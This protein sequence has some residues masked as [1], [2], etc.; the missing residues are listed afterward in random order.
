M[1]PALQLNLCR[2]LSATFGRCEGLVCFCSQQGPATCRTLLWLARADCCAPVAPIVG[3]GGLS[4]PVQ[5]LRQTNDLKHNR[6]YELPI[7][8]VRVDGALA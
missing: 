7:L 3:E 6:S 8:A 5:L 2:M 1:L 4:T